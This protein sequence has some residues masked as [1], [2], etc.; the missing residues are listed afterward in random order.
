MIASP[1][2]IGSAVRASAS[3]SARRA[4]RV[5]SRRVASVQDTELQLADRDDGHRDV[6]GELAERS[7]DLARDEDGRVQQPGTGLGHSSSNI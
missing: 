7:V 6:V 3:V 5:A 1:I 4:R 2:G